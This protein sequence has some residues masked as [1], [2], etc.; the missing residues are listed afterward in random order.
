MF[1]STHIQPNSIEIHSRTIR[2]KKRHTI[3]TITR[4]IHVLE[5]LLL[6][7]ELPSFKSRRKIQR[8]ETST[9]KCKDNK[10]FRQVHKHIQGKY[11]IQKHL[12]TNI[13]KI[14]ESNKSTERYKGNTTFRKTNK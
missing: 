13:R 5:D 2:Q 7:S 11:N 6:K 1:I 3:L 12:Q 14:Q 8:P 9:N 10:T 4:D